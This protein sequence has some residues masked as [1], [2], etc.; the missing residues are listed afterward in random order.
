MINS[1]VSDAI[2]SL[3][4][5]SL[6]EGG[7]A[8]TDNG[9]YRTDATAW[10]ILALSASGYDQEIISRARSR[11]ANTQ[12]PDGR[13]CISPDH[14]A[15]YWPTPLAI[16]AWRQSPTHEANLARAV[17]FLLDSSGT[18]W[19][20]QPNSPDVHDTNLKGWPWVAGTY[21]WIDPT[22]L[23]I[24]ALKVTGHS[25]HPRVKEAAHLLLDRQCPHGGWNYGNIIVFGAELRPMPEN[26]GMALD[27]LKNLAARS[28]LELSLDY[29]KIA[30]RNL[31]TPIALSW[32][33]LG[34][35]AW[36]E[37]PV[38]AT[39]WLS[40]CWGRQSQFGVYDTTSLSLLILASLSSGGIESLS[41]LAP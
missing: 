35:G 36:G 18:H 17:S 14:P 3:G 22:A 33:I 29:L 41:G 5:R 16:L 39:T 38:A 40:E 2:T 15:V 20:K 37:R 30:L 9:D 32:G 12:L 19:P 24:I 1:L 23:G 31:R 10:A 11:L 26:T 25:Q 7:F 4:K 27:A 21:S 13:I 28:S 8:N 6:V 34:L